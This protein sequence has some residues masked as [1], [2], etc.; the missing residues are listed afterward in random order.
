MRNQMVR[1]DMELNPNPK[2]ISFAEHRVRF[3][4]YTDLIT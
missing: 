4:E 3:P 2:L 1:L